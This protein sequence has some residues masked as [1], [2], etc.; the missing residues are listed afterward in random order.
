MYPLELYKLVSLLVN[1]W[2]ARN[3]NVSHNSQNENQL[4][5]RRMLVINVTSDTFVSCHIKIRQIQGRK[6]QE[7]EKNV[8]NLN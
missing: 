8:V 5:K 3:K 2:A 4:M 6:K 7:R 1:L